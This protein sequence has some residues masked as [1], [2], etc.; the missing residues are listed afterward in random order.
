MKFWQIL[1]LF[2]VL[3]II[4]LHYSQSLML[5]TMNHIARTEHFTDSGPAK[6]KDRSAA[7]KRAQ[8]SCDSYFVS[9]PQ[10][11]EMAKE[12]RNNADPKCKKISKKD[13]CAK[14]K[15]SG[16]D[17]KWTKGTLSKR[18]S[19]PEIIKVRQKIKKNMGV[20]T[21]SE[22]KKCFPNYTN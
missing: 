10:D 2:S 14:L 7:K 15:K 20:V 9:I 12:C 5:K 21:E 6:K 16:W 3:F 11:I 17:P 4:F 18:K 13:F 19:D 8:R 1:L 22:I